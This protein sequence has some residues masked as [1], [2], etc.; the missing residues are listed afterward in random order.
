MTSNQIIAELQKLTKEER[1]LQVIA[2][3]EDFTR[4][5]NKGDR[6]ELN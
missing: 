4:I 5:E 1:E 3:S 2:I 6:I